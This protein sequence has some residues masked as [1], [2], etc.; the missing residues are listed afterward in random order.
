ME[1]G[2]G[3][4]ALVGPR[5]LEIFVCSPWWGIT[6]MVRSSVATSE[7]P[8]LSLATCWAGTFCIHD[9]WI[10]VDWSEERESIFYTWGS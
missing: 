4:S 7:L 10:L 5:D 3:A 1:K 9:Y 6:R 8:F 2:S